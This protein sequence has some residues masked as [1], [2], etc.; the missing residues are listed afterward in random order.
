MKFTCGSCA[1]KYQI[2]DEKIAGRTLKMKCRKCGHPIV[3]RGG[4]TGGAPRPSA[5]PRRPSLPSQAAAP[6]AAATQTG[7]SVAP[8]PTRPSRT[9]GLGAEFRRQ[10]GTTQAAAAAAPAPGDEWHVS[11]DETPVGPL[12]RDEVARRVLE[13][14]IDESSLVWRDGFEAW[15]P[16]S[17]VAELASLLRARPGLHRPPPM[18]NRRGA[19]GRFAAARTTGRTAASRR[20]A[21]ASAPMP[22]PPPAGG[23]FPD[24][25]DAATE[26]LGGAPADAAAAAAGSHGSRDSIAAP[27]PRQGLWQNPGFVIAFVMAI[28]F[29][30]VLALLVFKQVFEA[31][32]GSGTVAQAPASP[33]P[34]SASEGAAGAVRIPDDEELD[35]VAAGDAESEPEATPTRAPEPR[36]GA[37]ASGGS[38]A[39]SAG[40][41]EPREARAASDGSGEM[42]DEDAALLARMRGSGDDFGGPTVRAREI[43]SGSASRS[44]GELDQRQVARVVNRNK[45]SLRQCYE[46]AIR[47]VT[48]APTVTYDVNLQ[49]A[50]SGRVSRVRMSSRGASLP[51]L[52][53][54][55][56][57]AMKRWVFPPSAEGQPVSFP[58]VLQPG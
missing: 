47:G 33:P 16:L 20:S 26:V 32:S 28:F 42:S 14:V 34:A 23:F 10:A 41:A 58:V 38:A 27:P 39:R 19:T 7:G 12:S 18:T 2:A 6:E 45:R 50:P 36:A 43:D 25:D 11:I 13:H 40:E 29:S 46:R 54:C 17:E 56:E 3:V 37:E 15:R 35:R 53:G 1:A 22:P 31:P 52:D 9:S 57:T 30:S 55:F 44:A 21:P 8:P 48:D 5:R 51:G 49:V 24:D 4:S